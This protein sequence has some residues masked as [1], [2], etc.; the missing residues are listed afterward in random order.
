MDAETQSHIFEPFFTTKEEGKGTGLGLATVFG[1][2]KQ[3]GGHVSVYSEL[4]RGTTFRVYLPRTDEDAPAEAEG[5]SPP[6]DLRGH[7]TILVVEDAEALRAMIREILEGAGYSV[8]EYAAP[9]TVVEEIDRLGRVDVLLTDVVLPRMR[10]PEL[11][12]ILRRTHPHLKVLFI[13]GY[14][15]QAVG[16]HGVFAPDSQF[17]QKP[18]TT[19]GL[20]AKVRALLDSRPE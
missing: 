10:G 3:S 19:A 20:L 12:G 4:G 16:H 2:V 7:E 18:F 9:A 5:T 13:S 6:S 14:T 15:D 8:L 1:I 17:L 11:A